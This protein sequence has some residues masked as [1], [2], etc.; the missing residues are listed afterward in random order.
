MKRLV[1]TICPFCGV[2][3]G[4]LLEVEDNKVL[5]VVPE[6]EHV[7]SKGKVCGKGAGAHKSLYLPGRLTKPLKRVGEKFVEI[8]WDEALDEIAGKLKEIRERY[9]GKA[10]AIYGLSLIHI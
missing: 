5:R 7:L 6:K 1:P 3:C 8:S 2:G 4:L 9:G 10:I